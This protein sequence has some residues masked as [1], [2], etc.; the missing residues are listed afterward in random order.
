MPRTTTTIYDTNNEFDWDSIS[1]TY[2]D[3]EL[4]IEQKT[5][6]TGFGEWT[7][8]RD[9]YVSSFQLW[10]SPDNTNTWNVLSTAFNADGD[11]IGEYITYDDGRYFQQNIT[12]G[13]V[14]SEIM[15]YPE[16]GAANELLQRSTSYWEGEVARVSGRY[17][18]GTTYQ[19]NYTDGVRDTRY[20]SDRT[21]DGTDGAKPW[22]SIT[23][24]YDTATGELTQRVTY[25]DDGTRKTE[26]FEDGVRTS[27]VQ[28][29]NFAYNSDVPPADGGVKAW[30]RIETQYDANGDIES[31]DTLF[32]N[33]ITRA[34]T[35]DGG[36]R[37]LIVQED[38]DDVK[39]WDTITTAY[40]PNGLVSN[41]ET[42]FDNGVT[43]ADLFEFG[44][45][46]GRIERDNFNEF[47]E[48]PADG[49]AKSWEEIT[50][51]YDANG[52]VDNR[53]TVFD[54]GVTRLEVFENGVRTVKIEQDNYDELG[55]APADGGV[56]YWSEIATA[57][58]ANGDI[59]LRQTVFDD[60]TTSIVEYQDGVRTFMLQTDSLD[61]DGVKPWEEIVT[62]YDAEGVIASRG[63]TFDNGVARQELFEDGTRTFMVEEDVFDFADWGAKLTTYDAN[64]V[65]D[66]RATIFDNSDQTIRV[67]EDGVLDALILGDGDNSE[68]W[69][70]R[71]TE[72][73]P[74]GPVTTDYD[75]QFDL[76]QQY[77]DLFDF[78]L[79]A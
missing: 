7:W 31:R 39:N 71:V 3:G 52:L 12:D 64:G 25:N 45:Q 33:G 32:D 76:P 4:A 5:M 11:I 65:V 79:V 14:T 8:F 29:D 23:L 6:D 70:V 50:T 69:E 36:T 13:V 30:E 46:F 57:Y 60:G 28:L 66:L 56:R 44:E 74:D 18:N 37:V 58:D 35:F 62:E 21:T 49:G 34:E 77:L 17:S 19:D 42:V 48:A 40:D 75:D 10:D 61:G 26:L 53:D 41:K 68:S 55:E 9:G 78:V 2:I 72:Y 54:N 63:T 27:T 16:T 38:V 20:W 73:T 1:T 59:A 67:F 15:S 22:T 24:R 47:G 51:S 43:R